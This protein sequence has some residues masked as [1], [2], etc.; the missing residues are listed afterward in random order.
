MLSGDLL[1]RIRL[2]RGLSQQ[3]IA[4]AIGVSKRYIGAIE[5]FEK[6]PSQETHDKWV[7]AVYTLPN[8]KKK[9]ITDEE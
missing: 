7:E 2:A 9:Q 1:K 6:N 4:T 8:K 3:D 5:R